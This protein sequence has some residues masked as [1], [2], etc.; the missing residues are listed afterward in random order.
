M[1]NRLIG[2]N[3]TIFIKNSICFLSSVYKSLIS[4]DYFTFNIDSWKQLNKMYFGTTLLLSLF[5]VVA[6]SLGD[7]AA[8]RRKPDKS[9]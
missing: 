4:H 3:L 7:V 2:L 8:K 5:L 9:M 6:L 1:S